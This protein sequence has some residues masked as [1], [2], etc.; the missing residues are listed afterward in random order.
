M[1]LLTK[2]G[3]GDDQSMQIGM[4]DLQRSPHS[5]RK[6]EYNFVYPHTKVSQRYHIVPLMPAENADQSPIKYQ[7]EQT[8]V[9]GLLKDDSRSNS[10][11]PVYK[12]TGKK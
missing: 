1:S 7:I 4:M 5:T 10:N 12:I 8:H 3:V 11:D 9:L 2:M 6:K